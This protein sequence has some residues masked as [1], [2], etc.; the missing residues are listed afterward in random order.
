MEEYTT[1]CYLCGNI[2]A[3][4]TTSLVGDSK[5][6]ECPS[7]SYY[8]ITMKAFKHFFIRDDGREILDAKDMSKLSQHIQRN[9]N[10][11]TQ[12][13]VLLNIEDI[14]KITGKA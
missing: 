1:K 11:Y 13:P 2:R 8:E 9:Y 14:K 5:K 3:I 6:V 4:E 10:P 7:C 12:K